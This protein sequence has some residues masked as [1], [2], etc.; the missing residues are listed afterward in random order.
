MNEEKMKREAQIN[1]FK[2][3][4]QKCD[5]ELDA[6]GEKKNILFQ[7]SLELGTKLDTCQLV[8]FKLDLFEIAVI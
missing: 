1:E 8:Y 7:N 4:A 2:E 3:Q 6:L 5:S